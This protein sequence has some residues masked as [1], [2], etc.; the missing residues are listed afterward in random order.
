MPGRIRISSIGQRKA[1][2]R[3]FVKFGEFNRKKGT[4]LTQVNAVVK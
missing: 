1:K 4:W 2:L 3:K